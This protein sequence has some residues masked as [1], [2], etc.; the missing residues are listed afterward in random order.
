MSETAPMLE[1]ADL[2][3]SDAN[4]GTVHLHGVLPSVVLPRSLRPEVRWD[5]LALIEPHDVEEAWAATEAEEAEERGANLAHARF[6]GGLDGEYLDR[7]LGLEGVSGGRFPDPEP[8]RL[9]RFAVR[10]QRPTYYLEPDASDEAWNDLLG[11]EAEALAHWR[12]MLGAMFQ[13]R[14][15]KRAIRQFAPHAVIPEREHQDHAIASVL[16]A[17]W[18]WQIEQRRGPDVA[19]RRWDRIARRLRGA[20][21]DLRSDVEDPVLLLP[22]IQSARQDLIEALERASDIERLL[23]NEEPSEVG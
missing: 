20:L 13:R 15:W 21:A 9:Q 1:W 12:T 3:W 19:R 18:W 6:S 22:M 23:R 4:G 16:A 8:R 11:D 17:V 14:R 7:L 5:G 2:I 10:H